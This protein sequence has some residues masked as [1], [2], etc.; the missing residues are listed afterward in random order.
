MYLNNIDGIDIT[1]LQIKLL[2]YVCQPGYIMNGFSVK[3]F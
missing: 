3:L 2:F 1:H